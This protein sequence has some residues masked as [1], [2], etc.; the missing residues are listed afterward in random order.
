V[1][2]RT[3]WTLSQSRHAGQ[4]ADGTCSGRQDS[5]RHAS[6]VRTLWRRPSSIDSE[7]ETGGNSSVKLRYWCCASNGLLTC[8]KLWQCKIMGFRCHAWLFCVSLYEARSF[9]RA[10][11]CRAHILFHQFCPS[12]HCVTIVHIVTFSTLWYTSDRKGAFNSG[13]LT[14]IFAVFGLKTLHNGSVQSKRS[15]IVIAAR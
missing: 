2:Q 14:K 12:V 10:S 5:S 8:E 15:L 1:H 11:A 6:A 9:Y 4:A 7:L 13:G 3:F